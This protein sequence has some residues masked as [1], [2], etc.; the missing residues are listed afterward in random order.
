MSLQ[1][2]NEAADECFARTIAVAGTLEQHHSV[3]EVWNGLLDEAIAG[4][5][6]AKNRYVEDARYED[7]CVARDLAEYFGAM[8]ATEDAPF[9]RG[10]T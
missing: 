3:I 6:R 1:L 5:I 10:Q 4:A 9:R 7:A 8:K 2:L